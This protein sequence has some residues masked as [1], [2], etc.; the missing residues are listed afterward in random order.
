MNVRPVMGPL[1]PPLLL[2]RRTVSPCH[3][4]SLFQRVVASLTRCHHLFALI[5][6][7]PTFTRTSPACLP[8]STLSLCWESPS[9]VSHIYPSSLHPLSLS[10]S[11]SFVSLIYPSSSHPL[12]V[13]LI[14][15]TY[16]SF[17]IH[18]TSPFPLLCPLCLLFLLLLYLPSSLPATTLISYSLLFFLFSFSYVSISCFPVSLLIMICVLYIYFGIV[19]MAPTLVELGPYF[20]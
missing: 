8:P 4:P 2:L 13:S 5:S 16:L 17:L 15:I 11:S 19:F 10:E 12:W 18:F 6:H 1:S 20:V 7:V 9:F 3:R 14:R